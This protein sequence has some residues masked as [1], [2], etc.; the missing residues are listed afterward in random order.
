MAVYW[1]LI[2]LIGVELGRRKLMVMLLVGE[3][4]RLY[5]GYWHTEQYSLLMRVLFII[6]VFCAFIDCSSGVNWKHLTQG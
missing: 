3:S 1:K 4:R 6:G 2:D 5:A